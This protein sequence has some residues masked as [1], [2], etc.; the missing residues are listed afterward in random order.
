MR[1][2]LFG[3]DNIL[4]SQTL[5]ALAEVFLEDGRRG[6]LE[7][8]AVN[9]QEALRIQRLHLN[10][11]EGMG[12]TV[13]GTLLVV[14]RIHCRIYRHNKAVKC[15]QEGLELTEKEEDNW[16]RMMYE[17]G[18]TMERLG[19]YQKGLDLLNGV[20]ETWE[21][22]LEEDDGRKKR[23]EIAEMFEYVRIL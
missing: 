2:K 16:A 7:K 19:K 15:F 21:K 6:A 3:V 9:S 5:L 8:G 22:S 23:L 1:Q 11:G 10:S 13:P 4:V 14:G 17:L 18:R 20:L 12:R